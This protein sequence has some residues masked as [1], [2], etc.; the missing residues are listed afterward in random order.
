M[1]VRNVFNLDWNQLINIYIDINP[2]FTA[3][4]IENLYYYSEEQLRFLI[5]IHI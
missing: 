3:K 5:T 4:E 2:D 1:Y